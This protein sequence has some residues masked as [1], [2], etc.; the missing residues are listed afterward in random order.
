[1]KIELVYEKSCP[2]IELARNHLIQAF[3]EAGIP[4]K[5]HEWEVSDPEAPS[6]IQG[7]GSPTILVNGSDVSG[8]RSNHDG[9]SCRIYEGQDGNI[10]GVPNVDLIAHAMVL[11]SPEQSGVKKQHSSRWQLNTAVLPLIGAAFLPKLA[12]PA[13][14]PAYAGLLSSLGIGFIDYTP[15]LLPLMILFLLIALTALFYRAASRHGYYPFY[16]G[17]IASTA[18]LVGQY[19][20]GSDAAMYVGLG[21]LIIS[22]IWNT[23]PQSA[24]EL[25]TCPACVTSD[26]ETIKY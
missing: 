2:N 24:L 22:S 26:D 25:K 10:T 6:Y 11:S 14:W 20:Y 9:Q 21:L 3:V 19:Y 7:C 1:M 12:C 17:L 16:L 23:W 5:W 8:D 18:I 13:C 4:A 15:Y